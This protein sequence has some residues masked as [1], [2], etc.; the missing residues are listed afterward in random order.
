MKLA[1]MRTGLPLVLNADSE[2]IVEIGIANISLGIVSKMGY[3]APV[4]FLPC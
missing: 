4:A 2:A 1:T 3:L